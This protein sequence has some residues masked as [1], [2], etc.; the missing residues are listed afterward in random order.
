MLIIA[1][2][3]PNGLQLQYSRAEISEE[4]LPSSGGSYSTMINYVS[5]FYRIGVIALS[6]KTLSLFYLFSLCVFFFTRFNIVFHQLAE[7]L[8]MKRSV[9]IHC[10]SSVHLSPV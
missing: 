10:R 1:V 8:F 2:L 9:F 4:L 7:S 5:V 3:L 6:L